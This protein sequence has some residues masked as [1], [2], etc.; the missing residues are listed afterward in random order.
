M[1]DMAMSSNG[2]LS[3][4]DTEM[5]L[6]Q[7]KAMVKK[8]GLLELIDTP[9][10]LDSIGGMDALKGY[11]ET[12]VRGLFPTYQRHKSLAYLYRKVCLSLECQVVES[13]F[14]PKHL[15]HSSNSFVEVGYG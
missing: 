12:K 1:L 4:E 14:A 15:Q 6:K 5:I 10:K 8:S 3:A 9:E 11:L 2:S 7:K 13:L